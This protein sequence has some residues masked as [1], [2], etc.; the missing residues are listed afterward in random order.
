MVI[1]KLITA[2]FHHRMLRKYVGGFAW[3]TV[4]LAIA[5][6]VVYLV[7]LML[8]YQ[9]ILPPWAMV[10]IGSVCNF[11]SFT[12]LHEAVHENIEGSGRGGIVTEAIGWLSG[13][14]FLAPF[15]PFRIIHLT[16]HQ[17][18]NDPDK[19]PDYWVASP[20]MIMS[21]L[22][23]LTIY[24]H[25]LH[26]FIFKLDHKETW[27]ARDLAVII[28]YW[29]GVTILCTTSLQDLAVYGIIAPTFLGT[30]LTAFLFDW[31]PHHPH[32][33]RSLAK[34]T[35]NYLG[36]TWNIVLAGQNM[37]QLHH[38]NPRI[39]FYRYQPAFYAALNHKHSSS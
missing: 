3:P 21:L 31:L 13:A 23:C 10:L 38:A 33:E 2:T 29:V 19:D 37:H 27:F 7:A 6:W 14:M 9:Q 8:L 30:G 28:A 20:S 17:H 25:Y 32:K 24:P 36:K 35:R 5:C 12:V 11:Y 26:M 1:T 22:R 39:P 16:H 18:T 4:L 34:H 15:R